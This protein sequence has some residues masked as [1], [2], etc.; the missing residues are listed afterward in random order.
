MI[1]R[2]CIVAHGVRDFTETPNDLRHQVRDGKVIYSF[3]E[4]G[5][6]RKLITSQVTVLAQDL[7]KKQCVTGEKSISS[8][9]TFKATSL[10]LLLQ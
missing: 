7:S 4:N 10:K 5:P 2:H 1:T 9:T 8:S 3:L 6:L